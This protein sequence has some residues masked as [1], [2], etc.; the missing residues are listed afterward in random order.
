MGRPRYYANPDLIAQLRQQFNLEGVP[1]GKVYEHAIVLLRN[2]HT[3]SPLV[4]T[5]LRSVE[6]AL[7]EENGFDYGALE[8]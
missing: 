8:L 5:C 6:G 3:G 1:D 7:E 2:D 4:A